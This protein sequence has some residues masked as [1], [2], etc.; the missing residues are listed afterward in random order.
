VWAIRERGVA[1]FDGEQWVTYTTENGLVDN[2]V[3]GIA[4]TPDG[5]IWIGTND[6]GVSRFWSADQN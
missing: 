4:V 1:R 2:D 3:S 5:A 6:G